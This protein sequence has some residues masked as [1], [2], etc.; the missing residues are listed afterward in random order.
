MNVSAAPSPALLTAVDY[1]RATW[2][3]AART[4]FTV[5]NRPHDYP[6]DMI[7]IHDIEGS[8]GSAIKVFQDPKRHGSAHY[9]ISY[10]GQVTQMVSEKDIAWHAGNW[11]YNTRAIGIEHEGYASKNLYTIPEYR[12]SAE[13]AGSI[14]S[15]WGVPMDRAHIIGHYQVPDPDHPGLFG[16]TDHH[17][18]PG[19]YWNW[20]L[21]ISMARYYANLL[22]S[23]PHMVLAATAY[24]G[25]GTASVSWP[26]ARTCHNPIDSYVVVAQPGG[27]QVT[28]PGTATSAG[29]TGLTNGVNYSFTVT[30]QN[31]DGQD[32]VSS[33][34][35]TPGPACTGAVLTATPVSPQS[36]GGAVLFAATSGTCSNPQYQFTVQSSNGTWVVQQ[37]FGR[38]TWTWDSYTFGAGVHRIGL[39]ANHATADPAQAEAST[40][41]T[42]ALSPFSM[43]DWHATFDMSKAPTSWVAGRSQTF[44]V[45]VTNSGPVTWPAAGYGRVD[46]ILHFAKVGGGSATRS[47]WLTLSGFSMPSNLA[48][49][50][51]VTFNATVAAPSTTGS[52]VLEAD[53]IKEHQFWLPQWQPV[54]VNVAAPDK[55]AG[56]DMGKVPTTWLAG[57]TQTFPVTVTNTS[58]YTWLA[59]GYFQ[60]NLDLHFMPT[61]GGAAKRSSWLTSQAFALPAN[62][63]PGGKAT[64]NVTVTAPSHTGAL[65]LEAVMIKEHAFWFQQWNPVNVTVSNAVWSASYNLTGAPAA[66]T[67][68]QTQSVTVTV[69]NTG[70]IAWPSAGYNRVDLDVHFTPQPAGSA[71]RAAWLTNQAFSMPADL[72]P[73][74]SVTLTVSVTAP[75]GAGSMYLEALMIKE[76]QFW[77][78]QSA[79]MPVTVS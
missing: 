45:T 49:G 53:M 21:Y 3:P 67:R 5:A 33:N 43:A 54:A 74:N 22:P 62:L 65:V 4:N 18:D 10:H 56:Y 25:D 7:V 58:N 79:S 20:T 69:T 66:W 28:V 44:P 13:L 60:T 29:F 76:H 39:W 38:N 70:N 17:T 63:A 71:N 35:V 36:A 8:Y 46:L 64:L 1:P 78:V 68:G 23:P 15:R 24:S 55:T 77:F 26:A 16:G 11:D 6:I 37:P 48:P 47:Q 40:T 32:T 50:A 42:Y 27:M 52:L 72:A 31:S 34:S 2:V 12:T 30:A 14:C 61:A 59:T 19:P 9:V 51:S 41:L 73:G 57:Q 75:A